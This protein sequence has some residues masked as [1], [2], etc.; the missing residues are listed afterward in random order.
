M[1]G[2]QWVLHSPETGA[3]GVLGSAALAN[4]MPGMGERLE[5]VLLHALLL[6]GSGKALHPTVLLWLVRCAELIGQ[7]MRCDGPGAPHRGDYQLVLVS[8]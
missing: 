4:P 3:P 1:P 5:P 6:R 8:Q 2:V 7:F